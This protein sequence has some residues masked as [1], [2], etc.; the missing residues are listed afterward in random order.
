[1]RKANQ[2]WDCGDNLH[3]STLEQAQLAVL[4]DIRDELQKLNR[5]FQCANFL[6]MPHELKT[7]RRYTQAR[8]PKLKR[9]K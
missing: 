8:W 1:M 7:L 3:S 4:M 9:A 2:I 5:V 6:N